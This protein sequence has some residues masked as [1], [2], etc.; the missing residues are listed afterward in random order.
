[1][2]QDEFGECTE[3]RSWAGFG[4]RHPLFASVFAVLLLALAGLPLTSGFVGKLGVFMAAFEAGFWPLVIVGVVSSAIAAFFYLRVVVMMFFTDELSES[5]P[6]LRPTAYS[7]TV[8]SIATGL[9]VL[10][11]IFPETALRAR[12]ARE[13]AH[14]VMP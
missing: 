1:M 12:S 3:L 10:L 14:I 13:R 11:G 8:A 9:T 4:Q 5:G 2:V 6:I 7:I